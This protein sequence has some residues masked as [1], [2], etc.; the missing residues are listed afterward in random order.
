MGEGLWKALKQALAD[1]TIKLSTPSYSLWLGD[2]KDPTRHSDSGLG[3]RV[4]I[5]LH[6]G[7]TGI[8]Q[9]YESIK[10]FH[11]PSRGAFFIVVWINGEGLYARYFWTQPC[12]IGLEAAATL[13]VE[14]WYEQHKHDLGF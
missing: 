12:T 1:G 2:V 5:L 9:E 6:Q 7:I 14:Q 13:M 3:E 10:V 8:H 11:V 4:A